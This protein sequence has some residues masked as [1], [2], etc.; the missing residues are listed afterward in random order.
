M[1]D[2]AGQPFQNL[3]KPFFS[4]SII[5]TEPDA[6]HNWYLVVFALFMSN[7]NTALYCPVC[8]PTADLHSLYHS[9][10]TYNLPILLFEPVKSTLIASNLNIFVQILTFQTQMC[11]CSNYYLLLNERPLMLNTVSVIDAWCDKWIISG[12]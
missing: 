2:T 11:V 5:H 1:V 6:Q 3:I 9:C 12:T 7:E 8:F 4:Y 10:S